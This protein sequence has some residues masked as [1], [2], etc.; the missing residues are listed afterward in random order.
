MN[1]SGNWESSPQ[2]SPTPSPKRSLSL[3]S[4]SVWD[5]FFALYN[6]MYNKWQLGYGLRRAILLLDRRPS[7]GVDALCGVIGWAV[8][9][10][11][12][13]QISV[14]GNFPRWLIGSTTQNLTNLVPARLN[15]NRQI[16]K[17]PDTEILIMHRPYLVGL[18]HKSLSL[19]FSKATRKILSATIRTQ[20]KHQQNRASKTCERMER[21]RLHYLEP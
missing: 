11:T 9:L 1:S 13:K 19:W 18:N 8:T 10:D 5:V 2:C 14:S 20:K 17:L 15:T 6:A 7:E 12:V 4:S 3:P 16:S 21:E